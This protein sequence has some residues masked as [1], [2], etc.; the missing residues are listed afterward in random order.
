MTSAVRFS[1]AI[2]HSTSRKTNPAAQGHAPRGAPRKTRGGVGRNSSAHTRSSSDSLIEDPHADRAAAHAAVR[3]AKRAEKRGASGSR[4][5]SGGARPRSCSGRPPAEVQQV[6]PDAEATAAEAAAAAKPA[7]KPRARKPATAAG[8]GRGGKARG[9]RKADAGAA[10]STA[11]H[12]G[13]AGRRRR[14]GAGVVAAVAAP[15]PALESKAH[16]R[17]L[18]RLFPF[19]LGI[20]GRANPARTGTCPRSINPARPSDSEWRRRAAAEAP[21]PRPEQAA[22]VVIRRRDAGRRGPAAA[23]HGHEFVG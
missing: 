20:A 3:H 13:P 9:G 10:S 23:L 1:Y 15:A 4:S 5:T 7:S 8:R 19:F 12:A 22:A 16:R 21:A 14:P 17:C 6:T 18:R 2:A 11:G